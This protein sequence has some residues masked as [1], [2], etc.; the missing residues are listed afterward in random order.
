M[1]NDAVVAAEV[2]PRK[3]L[4]EVRCFP[5]EGSIA[6]SGRF[7]IKFPILVQTELIQK[8]Q[9]TTILSFFPRTRELKPDLKLII[10]FKKK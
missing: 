7:G 1:V 4:R 6:G 10:N 5:G 8:G 9:F 3:L 2:A